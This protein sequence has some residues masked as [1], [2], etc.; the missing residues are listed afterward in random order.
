MLNVIKTF[1]FL[2]KTVSATFKPGPDNVHFMSLQKY[3][4]NMI[5]LHSSICMTPVIA[6]D[7][8]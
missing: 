4:F 8:Q 5:H 3:G 6:M 7:G 1:L 2:L